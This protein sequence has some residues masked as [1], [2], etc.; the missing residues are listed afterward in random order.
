MR[1]IAS[2][3]VMELFYVNDRK[4]VHNQNMIAVVA[5]R[6]NINNNYLSRS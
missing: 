5:V 1:E 4:K 2:V 6:P 3:K